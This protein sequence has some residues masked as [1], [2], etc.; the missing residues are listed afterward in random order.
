MK[1]SELGRTKYK[2]DSLKRK[3]NL[4]CEL[5]LTL[6]E[7]RRVKE[8]PDLNW[9]NEVGGLGERPHP[10]ELLTYERKRPEKQPRKPQMRF[11]VVKVH[12]N[13]AAKC[14]STVYVGLA[15]DNRRIHKKGG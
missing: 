1:K 14:I 7:V 9:N 3:R 13:L 15:L 11:K 6:R 2:A 5:G 12:F 8:S 10:V 4:R